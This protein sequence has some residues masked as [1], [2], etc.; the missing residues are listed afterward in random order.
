MTG[1]GNGSWAMGLNHAQRATVSRLRNE[2]SGGF[3][4]RHQG[5]DGWSVYLMPT[6]GP[7]KY[8]ELRHYMTGG[9][10]ARWVIERD[11]SVSATNELGE[12]RVLVPVGA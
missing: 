10:L 7:A 8:L 12:S 3:N 2:L 1:K 5:S 4:I 9:G 6:T 11:G